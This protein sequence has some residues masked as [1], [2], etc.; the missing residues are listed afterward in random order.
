MTA[1]QAAALPARRDK[2]LLGILCKVAG[3]LLFAVMFAAVRWLGPDFPVGQIVFWRST[4]GLAVIMVVAL[5]GGGPRLLATRRF[6]AHAFRSLSGVAA[7]F[8]NFTA[9][10]FLPLANVTALGFAA[11]LFGVIL[12]ALMLAESI[13]VYRWSAV[14]LGFAGVLV[15]VG[16]QAELGGGTALLGAAAALGGAGLTALA[17]IYLR[18]MSAHEH[19]ITIAFYFMLTTALISVLTALWGWN[20][21]TWEETAILLLTGLSGGFGQLFLSFSYRYAEVSLLAPFDYVALLWAAALGYLV[22]GEVPALQIWIGAA[23]VIAAGLLILWRE[24]RLGKLR[25]MQEL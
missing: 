12:A 2:P 1:P 18:R 7:M 17:M 15:I 25:S 16:P 22:F 10:I 23:I 4:T 24:H 6:D 14:F 8:C 19:S 5:A 3:T 20:V 9:Y 11:P 13:H 21:P